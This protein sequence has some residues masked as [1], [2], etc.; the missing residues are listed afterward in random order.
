MK[1]FHSFSERR[2]LRIPRQSLERS[3][4]VLPR[5]LGPEIKITIIRRREAGGLGIGYSSHRSSPVT[6]H[7]LCTD[8]EAEAGVKA[9]FPYTLLWYVGANA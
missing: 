2:V 1:A 3:S 4:I 6:L 8:S 9:A 7:S 5:H